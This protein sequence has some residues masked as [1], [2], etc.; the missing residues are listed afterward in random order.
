MVSTPRWS[1]AQPLLHAASRVPIDHGHRGHHVLYEQLKVEETGNYGFAP[2]R[3]IPA[4]YSFYDR[5]E[6]F[7][8]RWIRIDV[9]YTVV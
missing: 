1:P 4:V 8:L 7:K 2:A 9:L 3:L 5:F 6:W